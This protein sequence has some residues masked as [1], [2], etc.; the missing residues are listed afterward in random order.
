[1]QSE[2]STTILLLIAGILIIG[3]AIAKIA[4]RYKVPHPIPL[5][6]TGLALGR[7]LVALDPG[8]S[9][10]QIAGFDFIAQL[11]LATVLFYAGLTLNLRNLRLSIVNVLLLAT[12]GVLATSLIGGF[13]LLVTTATIGIPIGIAAFLIGAILSPTDPAALFSV[14]E[15]GGVRVKQKLFSIL[16]GEAVFNDATSVILVI[17]VFEPIVIASLANAVGTTNWAA[18]VGEFSA[19]IGLGV[20]LGY[21]VARIVGWAIPKAGDDTNISILTATTPFLAYGLGEMF[22]IFAIHPGALAAVFAGIFM[23]NARRIGL[24]PL[25]QRSMRRIM[26]NVSFFFEIVV[27]ILLGYTLSVPLIEGDP[28]TE[29]ITFIL[30]NPGI[31]VLGSLMAVLVILVARPISVFLVTA[32]DRK[33]GFK[34]RFFV[35]WAG[36][37][38]VA[39]AALAA[40]SV[41]VIIQYAQSLTGQLRIEYLNAIRNVVPTIYAVVFIVLLVSLVVQGLST[42]FFANILN[43]TEKV[44]KAKEIT[45]HRNATRQA[46]LNLVDQYTE[47]KIDAEVYGRFKAELEEEIFNLEVELRRIVSERRTRIKELKIREMIYTKKL[48]FYEKEYE[49]G[50][51]SDTVY[52]DLKSELEAAVEETINRIKIQEERMTREPE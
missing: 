24:Q 51:I 11:T 22:S 43:L 5:V 28:S 40:I 47:G 25:P 33:M 16:E 26:K 29:T 4:E 1:M 23:A 3:V 15:S 9:L 42:T 19:S 49:S 31:L 2:L 12:A 41:T 32:G 45:V 10:V 50:Q 21:I 14:L 39:S 13:T 6:L 38:G 44:D 18:I 46:L 20:G 8:T 36:V 7:V 30:A 27:F 17:T 52:Q 48:E 37:K 34:D 35:S